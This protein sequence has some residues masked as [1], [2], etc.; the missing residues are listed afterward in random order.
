MIFLRWREIIAELL[1][2]RNVN[3]QLKMRIFLRCRFSPTLRDLLLRLSQLLRYTIDRILFILKIEDSRV[4][5]TRRHQRK[6]MTLCAVNFLIATIWQLIRLLQMPSQRWDFNLRAVTRNKSRQ[7]TQFAHK[8]AN[9][10]RFRSLIS[11]SEVSVNNLLFV[12]QT[13]FMTLPTR[14]VDSL[15]MLM[16]S[17]Q[18]QLHEV[19]TWLFY[20]YQR[21]LTFPFLILFL[22]DA[23]EIWQKD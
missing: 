1:F 15:L 21:F 18:Q 7:M 2:L 13:F 6:L 4:S 5:L 16:L 9:Y 22:A 14:E 3:W 19:E 23:Y 17:C 20:F 10:N 8:M 12:D 11:H